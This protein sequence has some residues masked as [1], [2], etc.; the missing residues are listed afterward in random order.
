MKAVLL[1][2]EAIVALSNPSHRKHRAVLAH[3]QAAVARRHKGFD[4]RVVV[5][6]AVRVEAGWDRSSPRSAAINR[7]R[8]DDSILDR[9]AADVAASIANG[10]GVSVAD[11]HVGAVVRQLAAREIVVLTSDPKD[12]TAVAAPRAIRAIRV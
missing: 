9:G 7:F 11:A 6:T 2:C 3:V 12:M 1:D 4:V 5:P 8:V 10:S